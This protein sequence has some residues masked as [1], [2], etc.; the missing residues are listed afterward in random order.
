MQ[1]QRVRSENT[2]MRVHNND[3]TFHTFREYCGHFLYLLYSWKLSLKQILSSVISHQCCTGICRVEALQHI[4]GF[5]MIIFILSEDIEWKCCVRYNHPFSKFIP[6][7]LWWDPIFLMAGHNYQ[8]WIASNFQQQS[9][10]INMW[11]LQ[12]CHTSCWVNI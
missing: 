1:G 5:R 7:L 12:I 9:I 4:R 3:I 2:Y 11:T 10:V 8:D 6:L